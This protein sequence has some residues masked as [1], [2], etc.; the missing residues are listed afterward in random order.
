MLLNF[1]DIKKSFTFAIKEKDFALNLVIG[2]V[3]YLITGCLQQGMKLVDKDIL[4]NKN[5]LIIKIKGE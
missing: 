3:L 1:D 2:G 5:G 4:K